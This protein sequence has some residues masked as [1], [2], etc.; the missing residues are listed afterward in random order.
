MRRTQRLTAYLVKAN[1]TVVKAGRNS[2][3]SRGSH[4]HLQFHKSA[5]RSKS[6]EWSTES[7]GAAQVGSAAF[8]RERC[9]ALIAN[10]NR[11]AR[12]R[13]VQFYIEGPQEPRTFLFCIGS[14]EWDR[15]RAPGS[16]SLCPGATGRYTPG[17]MG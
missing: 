16:P 10:G 12:M 9:A 3:Y 8:V 6:D 5:G 2:D 14:A 11:S 7:G 1:A 13:P 17:H 4:L 15:V